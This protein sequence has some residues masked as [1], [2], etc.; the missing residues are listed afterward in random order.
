MLTCQN[1]V[2]FCAVSEAIATAALVLS[3]LAVVGVVALA[4]TIGELQLRSGLPVLEPEFRSP[5]T[6]PVFEL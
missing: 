2:A 1:E 4:R 6:L 3:L 5:K